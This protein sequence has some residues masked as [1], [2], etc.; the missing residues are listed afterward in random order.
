MAWEGMRSPLFSILIPVFHPPIDALRAAVDSVLAQGFRDWELILVDD[1]SR[2]DEVRTLLRKFA[3]ADTRISVTERVTNGGIVVASNDALELARGRFVALLD[4][5]DVLAS[6]ALS[7]VA[8]RIAEEPEVDYIYTDED[9]VDRDGVAYDPFPKPDWSPERLRSQMYTG[10]LSVLRTELVREVGGFA[11]DSD[12]SQDH[13]LVLRVTERARRI[14]HIPEVLYHWRAIKGSTAHGVSAKPYAWLA[15]LGAVQRHLD[16]MDIH[17]R[18]V[19]GSEPGT[20]HVERFLDPAVRVSVIIPTRGGRGFVW[21]E[22]RCLVVESVRSIMALA[23]HPSLEIVVVYDVPTPPKVLAQLR[24][25]AGERLV[26]VPF[27]EPFNFSAK[28]NVGFLASSGDAVIFMNDDM[29]VVTPGFAEQLVAPLFEEGVGATGARLLFADGR[30][31]HGGHVYASGDMT[32][33]GFGLAGDEQGPFGA[34]LINRE[35]SGLTAACLAVTRST[36][37][38]VGGFCEEL[39]GNFNDVD[40]SC[41]IGY[42]GRRLIWL[43][44]VTLYHFE[45][46]TRDSTVHEWEYDHIIR[47]W[48][49]PLR[50]PYFPVGY[51]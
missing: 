40:F 11:V 20:Y 13:D 47:R 38:D 37:E 16:R 32:H 30:L 50:D 14:I 33:A 46:L 1:C 12:G 7:A 26:L 2:S 6:G 18:A 43:S 15:G 36:F 24:E 39:P 17:G 48:G 49:I 4:H 27:E 3:G 5:D 21:G 29:Q 42:T 45:S 41:K 10:H 28:C 35:C 25:I 22:S 9:K 34:Y 23:T 51:R 44:Q 19:L 31:Q 8:S